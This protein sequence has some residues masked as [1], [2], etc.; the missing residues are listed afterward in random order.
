MKRISRKIYLWLILAVISTGMAAFF[1][2]ATIKTKPFVYNGHM[3]VDAVKDIDINGRAIGRVVVV[4]DF[5]GEVTEG[6]QILVYREFDQG[7]YLSVETVIDYNEATQEILTDMTPIF[8]EII[9]TSEIEYTYQRDGNGW[10]IFEYLITKKDHATVFAIS[11]TLLSLLMIAMSIATLTQK[12][13]SLATPPSV[14]HQL[15]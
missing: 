8:E 9:T 10:E 2:A 13:V 3:H 14:L 15:Y 4:V 7:V 5:D 1:I 12:K 6:L 11:T